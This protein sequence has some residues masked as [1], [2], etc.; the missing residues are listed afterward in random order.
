MLYKKYSN[1]EFIS[2]ENCISCTKNIEFPTKFYIKENPITFCVW[3]LFHNAYKK[4]F[5]GGREVSEGGLW[6]ALSKFW[7]FSWF[8]NALKQI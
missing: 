8:K 3:Y 5:F 1:S 4:E 7:G 2:V 6:A